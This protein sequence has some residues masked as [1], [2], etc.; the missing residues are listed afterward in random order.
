[1][2]L[3]KLSFLLKVVNITSLNVF[4]SGEKVT[5]KNQIQWVMIV[6]GLSV[7]IALSGCTP[8]S[9]TKPKNETKSEISQK[10]TQVEKDLSLSKLDYSNDAFWMCKPGI[11]NDACK[12]ELAATEALP[13]GGFGEPIAHEVN[14]DPDFDCFYIYW[15]TDL[16]RKA[17]NH[18]HLIDNELFKGIALSQA[19]RFNSVCRVFAPYYRQMTMGTYYSSQPEYETIFNNAYGDVDDAF[20]YY[21][22]NENNGRNVVLIGT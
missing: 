19:G 1:M 12:E 9:E 13:D 17:G 7:L 4:L 6:C 15:T 3:K 5:M 16:S 14:P 18:I 20:E 21:M 8:K 10:D 22:K 2:N 11:E